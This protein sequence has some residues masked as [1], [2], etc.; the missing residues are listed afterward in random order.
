MTRKD[1]AGL[2]GTVKGGD[3]PGQGVRVGM[4]GH[5]RVG[6]LFCLVEWWLP[7]FVKYEVKN[8]DESWPGLHRS[9]PHPYGVSETLLQG[10]TTDLHVSV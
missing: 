5:V 10:S 6:G 4:R 9:Q 1:S 3:H 8:L 7:F 2:N